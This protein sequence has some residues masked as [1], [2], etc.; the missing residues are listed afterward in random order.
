MAVAQPS[1]SSSFS[2]FS[3]FGLLL[4]LEELNNNELNKFKLL[5][6]DNVEPGCCP[7][8]WNTL[9]KA[10]REEVANLMHK[11]YPGQQAWKVTFKL[12]G[13]M[14]LRD[15]SAKAK[16]EMNWAAR[17]VRPEEIEPMEI[18]GPEPES[19]ERT[20]YRH[21]VKEKFTKLLENTVQK[22]LADVSL[23]ITPNERKV[24]ER[25][26]DVDIKTGKQLRTI[27][28]QGPT[29]VGKS[30]L[31]R[32]A[33]VEWAK[34]KLHQE[35]F[36]YI[37]YLNGREISQM[38]EC[39]FAQLLSRDWPQTEVAIE[40]VLS[41]PRSLLFIVD[42]FED[43]NF[44]FEEPEF[45]LCRDWTQEH[46]VSFL[47]S[48][49]LRKV[50]LP[51]STLLVLVRLPASQRLKS[52]VK[53][54]R[55]VRITGMT[56][57]ERMKYIHRY[58]GDRKLSTRAF[59]S[60]IKNE[61]LFK[62][63][64]VPVV[65]QMVCAC[66]KWQMEKGKTL[67]ASCQTTSALFTCYISGLF[68]QVEGGSASLPNEIQLRNLCHLAVE[69]VWALKHVFYKDNFR[70]HDLT[71]LDITTFLVTKLL[72][73][74][75]ELENCYMFTHLHIQE[76]LA[77]L[78]Y[79]LKEDWE[80][81]DHPVQVYQN[82][83]LLME[84]VDSIHLT[85]MKW[86]LF[87]LFNQDR[88]NHLEEILNVKLSLAIKQHVLEC[89]KKLANSDSCQ[90]QLE[91]M[92]LFHCLY[93][94]QDEKFITQ[95][96]RHFPDIV[97]NICEIT[98]LPVTSFCLKRSKYVRTLKFSVT[99]VFEK[100]LSTKPENEIWKRNYSSILHS[101]EQFCSV[102]RKSDGLR[103]VELR[104]ST[105]HEVPMY[106]LYKELRDPKC[107]VQKL[108]LRFVS[109][110][111]DST[112]IFSFLYQS[113][114]LIHLELKAANVGDNGVLFLCEALKN[115]Q[116]Q[117]QSLRLESCNLTSVCC[118]SLAN[119]LTRSYSLIF[120]DLSANNLLDDGAKLLWEA[121][122]NPQCCIQ[123]LSLQN[124]GLTEASCEHIS[125]ALI[126]NERLTHLCLADN[127]LGDNGISL[128]CVALIKPQCM[129][130]SLVLRNCCLTP[131][132][133]GCIATSLLQN[134]SLTHLDLGSNKLED[135]GVRLLW[136][137][138]RQPHCHLQ[139]LELMGCV[140]TK[141]CCLD[142]AV[143]ILNNRSLRSLD[144]GNNNLQNEGMQIL[145]DALRHPDC[146]LESLGLEQCGLTSVCCEALSSSLL[147]NQRLIKMNL[148][149]NNLGSNGIRRLC[150]VLRSPECKLQVLGLSKDSYDQETQKLL[151]SVRVTNSHLVIKSYSNDHSEDESCCSQGQR[152]TSELGWLR[153]EV[154]GR[155]QAGPGCRAVD[156]SQTGA[157][158][159]PGEA[160]SG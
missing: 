93:E 109:L 123:K 124:C 152:T 41:Q 130:R 9:K 74:D 35:K 129:L 25:T 87:G 151:E 141:A 67:T 128:I 107:K 92:D 45:A 142:L 52:V 26:F 125:M 122:G 7:I 53:N 98:H 36:T 83:K 111:E 100:I 68:A 154:R 49:L 85:H 61:M 32:K 70:K 38:R 139:D 80:F 145:C 94:T 64:Q 5:L 78:F 59:N 91:L 62:M 103:E 110:P 40:T 155:D 133:S 101:W 114:T 21:Q 14:N 95:V 149:Q 33:M 86:F 112:G 46:P 1:S 19:D 69:G 18:G 102:L 131:L 156:Q 96:M 24:L 146:N 148:S 126:S 20:G 4:Y 8:P 6:K 158:H 116:C 77:A 51:E 15:L 159:R 48:S 71:K 137:L 99:T 34:G 108:L 39:T 132:G 81:S 97:L 3:D 147:S 58:F 22:D 150:E 117:L 84:N 88:V 63:C 135:E 17:A 16:A 121:L 136:E 115:T 138:I 143:S 157:S 57:D 13:K 28:M 79:L 43:L 104:H 56:E 90:S 10:R 118:T 140:L 31:M 60:L 144:L 65:C 119:I 11:Y 30:T 160:P 55:C 82:V 106:M 54:E 12:F 27:V 29:G 72:Q 75:C 47:M 37:F 73:K 105:L 134:K 89:I 113:K 153:V 50:M 120:L 42:S 127:V 23:E 76:F 2:F 44:A 66:L